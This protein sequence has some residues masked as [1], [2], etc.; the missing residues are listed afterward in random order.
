MMHKGTKILLTAAGTF[1]LVGGICLG[2]GM[3]MGGAPGFYYDRDGIHVKENADRSVRSD[4][5]LQ[6][7][8]L[9]TVE[10]VDICLIEAR[11][12]IVP[13]KE[14]AVEYVLE[15]TH[16]QPQYSMEDHTLTIREGE[17]SKSGSQKRYYGF[18]GWEWESGQGEQEPYVKITVPDRAQL[19]KVTVNNLYGDIIVEKNLLSREMCIS[20]ENGRVQLDGWEGGSLSLEMLYGDLVTGGLQGDAVTVRNESGTVKTGALQAKTAAFYMRYGDLSATVE[21]VSS[22]EVEN[23]SGAVTLGL[24]GGMDRHGVSLHSEWG[25]IRTPQGKV[26]ADG[27]EGNSDFIRME[28]D[29]AGVRVY[30]RYGDIRVKDAV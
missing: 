7:T 20:A 8:R 15:G 18:T 30:T 13:G 24:V 3:A 19:E 16:E 6:R 27:E 17:W 14:W 9:D 21:K 2:A 25:A 1:M 29:A 12:E 28:G 26:E 5:V 11:L 4:Y 22:M 23:E 10:N